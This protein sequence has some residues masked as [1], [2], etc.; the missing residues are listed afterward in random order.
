VQAGRQ[1]HTLER[2]LFRKTLAD[3]AQDRHLALRP[4]DFT[5]ASFSQVDVFNIRIT[6][7]FSS[8]LISKQILYV[9]I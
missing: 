4:F 1:A 9:D 7:D 2:F 5:T 8:E 3:Q 6:H